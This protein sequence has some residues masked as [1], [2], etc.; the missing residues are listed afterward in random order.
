MTE[1]ISKRTRLWTDGGYGIGMRFGA[2]LL[3]SVE[4][5]SFLFIDA[6]LSIGVE[7]CGIIFC[8]MR[9]WGIASLVGVRMNYSI[10]G[11]VNVFNTI[12]GNGTFRSLQWQSE[13]RYWVSLVYLLLAYLRLTGTISSRCI[14][15]AWDRVWWMFTLGSILTSKW[16]LLLWLLSTKPCI[17]TRSIFLHWGVLLD[18]LSSIKM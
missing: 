6:S 9:R 17:F 2:W 14:N 11:V 18:F 3:V 8:I 4:G 5:Q 16:W 1:G 13:K 15:V 7:L 10:M 12:V